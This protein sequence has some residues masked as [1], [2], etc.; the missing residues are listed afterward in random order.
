MNHTNLIVD[1]KFEYEQDKNLTNEW[2]KKKKKKKK[3]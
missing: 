1:D 3:K 2:M